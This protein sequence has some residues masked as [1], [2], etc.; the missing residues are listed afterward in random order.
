M[1]FNQGMVT[2]TDKVQVG[3]ITTQT[4][5]KMMEAAGKNDWA[6][7]VNL[8]SFLDYFISQYKDSIYEKEMSRLGFM[9]VLKD[10][11]GKPVQK[12]GGGYVYIKNPK[13]PVDNRL[14]ANEVL[15]ILMRLMQRSNFMPIKVYEGDLYV[16]IN[17]E[18]KEEETD[19]PD[20]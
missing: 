6:S 11:K 7:Y 9:V 12:Q 13:N 2:P 8:M 20:V 18:K 17:R 19:D 4:L 5:L 3:Y 1:D 16:D 14:E 15:A 10:E